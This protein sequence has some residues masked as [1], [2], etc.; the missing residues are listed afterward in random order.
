MRVI[1]V[2]S[3]ACSIKKRRS[4]RTK[5]F[6]AVTKTTEP[7]SGIVEG[8]QAGWMRP[9]DGAAFAAQLHVSPRSQSGGLAQTH[10]AAFIQDLSQERLAPPSSLL[11]FGRLDPH[12]LPSRPAAVLCGLLPPLGLLTEAWTDAGRKGRERYEPPFTPSQLPFHA[13]G[14]L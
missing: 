2:A 13:S 14:S 4:T 8:V 6:I 9:P 10:E 11:G 1:R 7:E 3:T 12:P 5:S